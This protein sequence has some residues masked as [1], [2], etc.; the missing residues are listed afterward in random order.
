MSVSLA[1]V[2]VV[3][4]STV[5]SLLYNAVSPSLKSGKKSYFAKTFIVMG[6]TLT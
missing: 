4:R 5:L 3:R 6:V 2:S 1:S